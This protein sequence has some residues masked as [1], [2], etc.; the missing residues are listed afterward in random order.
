MNHK[1][2][3]FLRKKTLNLRGRLLDLSYP[4]VMGI[5][6]VT[7]D[8]FYDGSRFHS[9]NEIVEAAGKMMAEGASIIDVGGYSSR[10]GAEHVNAEIEYDRVVPAVES[11]LR[12]YPDA[13]ISVDTFRATVAEASLKLGACIINDISGGALDDNMYAT[14][15][16]YKAAY[17]IMHMRGTPENMHSLTGYDDLPLE[18]IDY[19]QKKIHAAHKAGIV[20]IIIDPG[21]GFSKTIEENYHLLKNLDAFKVLGYPLLVGISRKS[22]IYKQLNTNPEKALNGTTALNAIA[23]MNSVNIL[24]VHDVYQ[25]KEV[26]TLYKS[27]Y[28]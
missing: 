1:D 19:F 24:R 13:I 7:P 4:V 17:I 6:N 27:I 14:V 15:A 26:I 25:A 18:L 3:F 20:D 8:S 21:F 5:L 16:H 2:T 12:A 23:L 11:I 10:P 28:N 22:M 9:P